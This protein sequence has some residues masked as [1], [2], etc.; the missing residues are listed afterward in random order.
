MALVP[1]GLE[2]AILWWQAASVEKR[3]EFLHALLHDGDSDQLDEV[4]W[5]IRP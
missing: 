1:F 4:T 5:E 3:E 2:D